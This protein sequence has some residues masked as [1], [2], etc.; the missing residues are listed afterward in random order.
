MDAN[1]KIYRKRIEDL[2]GLEAVKFLIPFDLETLTK[3]YK[4]NENFGT[5]SRAEWEKAGK[6]LYALNKI[7]CTNLSENIEILKEAARL[8]VELD[9]KIMKTYIFTTRSFKRGHVEGRIYRI[10]NNRPR[11]VIHFEYVTG[12]T[13]GAVSEAFNALMNCGEIPKKWY[14]SSESPWSGPGYFEGEV[15]NYYEILEI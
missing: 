7:T 14:T 1:A 6:L 2:G 13:K 4:E 5:L 11:Y 15:R 9:G 12:C 3:A 10:E 8:W